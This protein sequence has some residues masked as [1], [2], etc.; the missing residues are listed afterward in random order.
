MLR[1][2]ASKHFMRLHLN[3]D[4]KISRVR[5]DHQPRLYQPIAIACPYQHRLAMT[6]LVLPTFANAL[7]PDNPNN[8][9]PDEIVDH[10]HDEPDTSYEFARPLLLHDLAVSCA[11]T[12]LLTFFPSFKPVPEHVPQCT[13]R[14]TL[15]H[16]APMRGFQKST[17]SGYSKSAPARTS[18][19]RASTSTASAAKHVAKPNMSAKAGISP[20]SVK[21]GSKPRPR[22]PSCQI[23][24]K[25]D[26]FSDH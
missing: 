2:V 10:C 22:S 1:A 3:R 26:S 13:L 9:L 18:S 11:G 15:I 8:H 4:V 17:V 5:R 20:T 14:W 23:G 21:F 12:T 7:Y 6:R 16:F 19:T 25:Y 24:R